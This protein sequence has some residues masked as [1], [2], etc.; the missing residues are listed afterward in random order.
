MGAEIRIKKI[1]NKIIKETTIKHTTV[2]RL[3]SINLQKHISDERI[4]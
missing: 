3:K 1:A 2:N 4:K